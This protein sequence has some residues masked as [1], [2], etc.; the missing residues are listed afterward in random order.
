MDIRRILREEILREAQQYCY[1]STYITI[2]QDIDEEW[3]RSHLKNRN[4]GDFKVMSGSVVGKDILFVTGRSTM[5][6]DQFVYEYLQVYL[7]DC[8]IEYTEIDPV[9][10]D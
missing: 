8:G 2:G 6:D 4:Y 5:K 10:F 9:E 7:R 1:W 3:F